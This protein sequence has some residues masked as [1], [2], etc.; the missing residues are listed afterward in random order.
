M[1]PARSQKPSKTANLIQIHEDRLHAQTEK[2]GQKIIDNATEFYDN[3]VK[4][5]AEAHAGAGGIQAKC[6]ARFAKLIADLEAQDEIIAAAYGAVETYSVD[7]ERVMAQEIEMACSELD[8][9]SK[10]AEAAKAE[11]E[12]AQA[13]ERAALSAVD[14]SMS[15]HE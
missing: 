1:P 8:R 9:A 7:M 2:R 13:Q 15:V 3:A 14:T 10:D 12:E 11:I 5:Y 4:E 6:R